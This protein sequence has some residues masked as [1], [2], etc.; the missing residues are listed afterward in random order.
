[1]KDFWLDFLDMVHWSWMFRIS[2]SIKLLISIFCRNASV[3]PVVHISFHSAFTIEFFHIFMVDFIPA[4]FLASLYHLFSA[5]LNFFPPFNHF[6]SHFRARLIFLTNFRFAVNLF[7]RLL[8]SSPFHM[9]LSH[10]F[11]L[12]MIFFHLFMSLSPFFFSLLIKPILML[13]QLFLSMSPFF[14]K[15]FLLIFEFPKFP[16]DFN[17]LFFNL[18]SDFVFDIWYFD[19]INWFDIF[20]SFGKLLSDLVLDFFEN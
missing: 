7:F 13:S 16:I 12:L 11:P 10:L 18:F 1:M 20:N 17:F 6:G 2:G 9:F 5:L 14:S 8:F 19:N 15:F 3:L 4:L